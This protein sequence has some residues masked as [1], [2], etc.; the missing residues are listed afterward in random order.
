MRLLTFGARERIFVADFRS[1]TAKG[2]NHEC[3]RGTSRTLH[4]GPGCH[5]PGMGEYLD[6]LGH[7]ICQESYA[8]D[9]RESFW[10]QTERLGRTAAAL[11]A[12]INQLPASLEIWTGGRAQEWQ[13][14]R[15]RLTCA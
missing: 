3:D 1:V 12:A 15:G 8:D 10:R 11:F 9:C 6:V 5:P 14:K 7:S 13:Q 4:Q 2:H